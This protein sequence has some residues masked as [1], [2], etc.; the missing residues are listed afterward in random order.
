M[1]ESPTSTARAV[2]IDAMPGSASVRI[3]HHEIGDQILG[4]TLQHEISGSLPTLL[5]HT[6][7]PSGVAFEGLARVAV[8]SSTPPAEMI[9]E[10]LG[11]VDPLTLERAALNR[12]DLDNNKGAATRAILRQLTEWAKDGGA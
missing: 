9:V 11:S 2:R 12:D 6:R 4:Y 7:Q 1:T 5:L 8:A 10:F 3:D